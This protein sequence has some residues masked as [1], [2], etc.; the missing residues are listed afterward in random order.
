MEE[1]RVKSFAE[2]HEALGNHRRDAGWIYRGHADPD[3]E[4]VPR[5]G[6]PPFAGRADE[7][8][9]R[10]WKAEAIQDE[11]MR[12]ED[13]WNW[14]ALAQHHGFATRMLD[15]TMKPLAAAWFAVMEPGDGDSVIHCFRTGNV[16]RDTQ[17]QSPFERQGITQFTPTRVSQR[18][19]RQIGVFTHHSPPTLAL[20][21][22]MTPLDRL[23]RIIIDRSYRTELMFELNQYG[24]NAQTLFP[25]LVGLSR[26]F[27]WIMASFDYWAEGLTGLKRETR[28]TRG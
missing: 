6:R 12:P 20:D 18:V 5:A 16:L 17:A 19:S 14:L 23:E 2:L 10:R 28:E 21:K 7:I 3:W 22:G 27:N 25:H 11:A 13:D 26:H 9:F 15:W 24:V 1:Y 4:L 8:F